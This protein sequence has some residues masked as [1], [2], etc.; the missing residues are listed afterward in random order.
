MKII[1]AADIHLG[2]RRFGKISSDGTNE[3]EKDV[4]KVFTEFLEK[5][6]A[7]NPYLVLVAGDLFDS[8]RPSNYTLVSVF[9]ALKASKLKF[10]IVPG[11]HDAP[12]KTEAT[13]PIE[14]LGI[15]NNVFVVT[16]TSVFKMG[17]LAIFHLAD[18]N[19]DSLTQLYYDNLD[20][21]WKILIYHGL[22]KELYP[23]AEVSVTEINE[24]FKFDYIALGDFHQNF[25]LASN[26]FYSG[27][28]DFVSP[29]FWAEAGRDKGFLELD[30]RNGEVNFHRL[31][32]QRRVVVLP[33]VDCST[34]TE[35]ELE[36]IL[37]SALGNPELFG[38]IVRLVLKNFSPRHNKALASRRIRAREREIF[39]LS[40]HY[41]F[42]EEAFSTKEFFLEGGLLKEFEAF[43]GSLSL[44]PKLKSDLQL[45]FKNF[46]NEV[47]EN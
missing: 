8:P 21:R 44:E 17:D 29:N 9:K 31:R 6:E 10:L 39:H 5:A 30:L 32:G 23:K 25:K 19:L 2:H 12:K 47:K 20:S 14:I 22:V 38:A 26:C 43:L 27:S 28:F 35:D 42:G 16:K 4:F 37:H 18:G 11:N 46:L 7:L 1:H 15:L 45:R 3:R 33:E 36:E 41:E 34:L 24:R 40:V 13:S